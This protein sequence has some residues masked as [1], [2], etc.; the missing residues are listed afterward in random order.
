MQI[1]KQDLPW[2]EQAYVPLGDIQ[3]G[4]QGV[5][6]DLLREKV[7]EGIRQNAWFIGL[8]DYI[9]LMPPSNRARLRAANMYEVVEEELRAASD[10][11]IK[12]LLTIFRGT[13][14]RWLGLVHG[15]HYY[16]YEDGTTSD[17][18]LA[19]ALGCPY[20]GTAAIIK[21]HF[22]RRG[23]SGTLVGETLIQHGQGCGQL[24]SAPL[25]RI[26]RWMDGWDNITVYLMAHMSK[27]VV[28]KKPRCRST[29]REPFNLVDRERLAI[30]TGCYLKGYQVGSTRNGLP[31]GN[32][33]EEAGM[34][35]V[36]L[37]SPTFFLRPVHREDGDEVIPS[38]LI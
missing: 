37:G 29:Q 2:K 30:A 15:H 31:H 6:V 3:L 10:R 34:T 17:S 35:P 32:Y 14:G 12:E 25:N 22:V 19:K 23:S 11:H 4:A 21:H 1:V 38:A 28:S 8:G 26:E 18:R 27:K 20:L 24:M 5:A 33:I 13:E 36:S 16:D 7:K 9:D